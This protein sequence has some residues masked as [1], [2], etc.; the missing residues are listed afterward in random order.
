MRRFL[1]FCFLYAKLFAITDFAQL[2]CDLQTAR[3]YDE[4]LCQRFPL[5]YNSILSTG[6]FVTPSARMSPE[7]F[8][9][10]GFSYQPPYYLWNGRIQALS[11]L[12]LSANYRLVKLFAFGDHAK[13]GANFKIGLLTPEESLYY[14]PGIAF[15]I[16]NFIGSTTFTNYFF[17]GTQIWKKAG[18]ETSIGWGAGRYTRGPSRGVFG[19]LCW[20]PMWQKPCKWIKGMGFAA[21]YDPIDYKNPEREPNPDGGVS[22]IPINYG[23]TYNCCDVLNLTVGQIR[24]DAVAAYGSINYNWGKFDGFFS[25][26]NDPP[27]YISP[28]DHEPIGCSRPAKA[29]AQHLQYAFTRQ[30]FQILS[31]NFDESCAKLWIKLTNCCY[32]HES[33]MRERLQYLLTA[34]LPSNVDEVTVAVESYGVICQQ[35]TYSKELLKCFANNHIDLYDFEALTPR[36]NFVPPLCSSSQ[37]YLRRYDLW[38]WAITPS[39]NSYIGN[40]NAKYKYSAGLNLFVEGF[41]P[42]KIYYDAQANYQF[43]STLKNNKQNIFYTPSSLQNVATDIGGYINQGAF[44][45]PHLYV[46]RSWNLGRG[47]FTRTALGYFQVNYAGVAGEALWYPA[48][49]HCAIGIEGAVLKKRSYRGLG[50]QN[51]VRRIK[52]DQPIWRPYSIFNQYFLNFYLDLPQYQLFVKAGIGG[53]LAHDKGGRIEILRYFDN[54]LRFGGWMTF[55]D[56]A[57]LM[58]GE[59]YYNRGIV[60]EIPLD[61]FY[62]CSCKKVYSTN[63]AAWLRDAGYYSST[64]VGLFETINRERRF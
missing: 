58:R 29:L 31:L 47:F 60:L 15:G 25:K 56:A 13:P 59:S 37:F 12:E 46:Q 33:K 10:A 30:G 52:N 40:Q 20:F 21:E 41:L 38:K 8:I 42:G 14:L 4:K 54:G 32:I 36:E 23:F 53:F 3:Y 44:I 16:E 1:V 28:K 17:V 7:G 6:Y 45:W 2:A 27:L 51:E 19:G 63:T 57:D 18:L 5:T 35:Y 11:R 64:G 61:F 34:L 50:F 26:T 43:A 48:Q 39:Y 62:R 49:S 55:T 24:G 9:G 22:H